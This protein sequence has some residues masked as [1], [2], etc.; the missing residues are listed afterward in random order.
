M[1]WLQLYSFGKEGESLGKSVV[2]GFLDGVS[3]AINLSNAANLTIKPN[4]LPED[5]AINMTNEIFRF[6]TG[7]VVGNVNNIICTAIPTGNSYAAKK[8][9][10]PKR[11]IPK[12][13]YYEPMLSSIENSIR[14]DLIW[15][16]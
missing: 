15:G 4:K 8:T 1:G 16:H 10:K 12:N 11:V 13:Y 14:M 2:C 5:L 3:S 9:P 6:G 7:L